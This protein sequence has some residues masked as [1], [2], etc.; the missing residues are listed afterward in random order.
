MGSSPKQQPE[1]SEPADQRS[2]YAREFVEGLE[3]GIEQG[4]DG[5]S[6]DWLA[7]RLRIALGLRSL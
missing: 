5:Q 2:P 1:V 7:R 6:E 4:E 3:T